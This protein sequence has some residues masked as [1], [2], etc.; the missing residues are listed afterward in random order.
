M[1]FEQFKEM[2]KQ[3]PEI[4]VV[5]DTPEKFVCKYNDRELLN[6][7]GAVV[8]SFNMNMRYEYM[9]E[10]MAK[11]IIQNGKDYVN[12]YIKWDKEL[13]VTEKL[14]EIQKDFV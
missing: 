1:T 5:T 8:L 9:S 14:E 13:R 4:F 11:F 12:H 7:N 6:S 3:D 2:V 10:E